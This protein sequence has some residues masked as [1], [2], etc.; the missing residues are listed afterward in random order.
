[1][2]SV[3]SKGPA[4]RPTTPRVSAKPGPPPKRTTRGEVS[5]LRSSTPTIPKPAAAKNADGSGDAEKAELA[6]LTARVAALEAEKL[7]LEQ[8]NQALSAKVAILE[9]EKAAADSSAAVTDTPV[10]TLM[11]Q[12]LKQFLEEERQKGTSE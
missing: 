7:V 8:T 5:P 1:M 10:V 2:K 3:P 4:H 6:G 9:A 12:Q 11:V